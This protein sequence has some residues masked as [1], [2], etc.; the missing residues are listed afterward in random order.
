MKATQELMNEHRIIERF[1]EA[2]RV[3]SRKLED[4]SKIS[5]DFFLQAADFIQGFADGCHHRKEEG[6]LFK[7][8]EK[9]GLTA[10]SGPV[11]VMLY[12]HEQ[13][14]F[15]TRK[16]KEAAQ[17]WKIGDVAAKQEV[18]ANALNY[19]ALLSQHIG[20]EDGVLFP[21]ADR[22]I[23]P[24]LHEQ[25]YRDFEKV[26]RQETGEGVHEKYVNLVYVLEKEAGVI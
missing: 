21:M 23:P 5:P 22:L 1:L 10:E 25:V 18:I 12:E 6:V 8:L 17:R 4:D 3:A 19:A 2:L 15:F 9:Y 7:T 16:M 14:R 26:E 11:G 24:E 13:G 20:K